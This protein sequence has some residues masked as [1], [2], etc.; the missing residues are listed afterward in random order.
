[1]ERM[2]H[3]NLSMIVNHYAKMTPEGWGP[4]YFGINNLTVDGITIEANAYDRWLLFLLLREAKRRGILSIKPLLLTHLMP[5][6]VQMVASD[7]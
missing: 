4:N 6:V 7:F 2:G 1:M 5:Q 3:A